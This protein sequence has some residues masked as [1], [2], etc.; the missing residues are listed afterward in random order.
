MENRRRLE[1]GIFD[2]LY[3]AKPADIVEAAEVIGNL[4]CSN[5][6]DRGVLE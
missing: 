6:H 4:R 3:G 1:Q 2:I 5:T